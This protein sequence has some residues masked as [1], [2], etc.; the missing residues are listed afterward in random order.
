MFSFIFAVTLVVLKAV[1]ENKCSDQIFYK[2]YLLSRL[3]ND[4]GIARIYHSKNNVKEARFK[5]KELEDK[6][7]KTTMK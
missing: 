6:I 3:A 2:G 1:W 4:D 5:D 7:H